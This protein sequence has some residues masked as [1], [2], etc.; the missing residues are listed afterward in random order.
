MC[1]FVSWICCVSKRSRS[2][3]GWC[4]RYRREVWDSSACDWSDNRCNGDECTEAAVSVTAALKGNADI[5]VGNIVGSNILNILII[6]GITAVIVDVAVAKSTLC[7]ELPYMLVVTVVLIV[8]GITGAKIDFV[9]GIM[10]WCLF[11]LYLIYLYRMA[12]NGK[13]EPIQHEQ[14]SVIKLLFFSVIGGVF[15]IAGSSFTVES[16]SYIARFLGISERFIGLTVVALGT[17]LPELVTS[18]VAARKGKA[19]I[20]IGNIGSN[21]LISICDWY[22]ILDHTGFI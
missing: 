2:F 5:T 14:Q 4:I 3:C 22:S 18:V 9:E 13:E 6:L 20:A 21:I 17:S 8:M 1:C 19:D 15:I 10:L 7:Y 12:K 16:A 11:I